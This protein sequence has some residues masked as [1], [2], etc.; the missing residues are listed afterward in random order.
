MLP[1]IVVSYYF[2][3]C[4]DF[5]DDAKIQH[6]DLVDKNHLYRYMDLVPELFVQRRTRGHLVDIG[7]LALYHD[8]ADDLPIGRNDFANEPRKFEAFVTRNV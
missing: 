2:D 3:F 6:G 4:V 7:R 8:D 1:C 5:D